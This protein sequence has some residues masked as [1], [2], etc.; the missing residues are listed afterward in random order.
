MGDNG[1]INATVVVLGDLGRS[2]RMQYHALSL[3]A[4]GA[5]VD[6]IGY[7]GSEVPKALRE[8]PRIRCHRMEPAPGRFLDRFKNSNSAMF[9]AVSLIRIAVQSLRLLGLLLFSVRKPDV[10]VLQN[11]PGIPALVILL[12]S[13]R[14]KSARLVVDW[15]NFGYTM[16]ALRLGGASR[17]VRLTRW[18]ERTLGRRADAHLCVS[19]AMQAELEKGWGFPRVAVLRDRPAEIF[20]PALAPE[21]AALRRR[22]AAMIDVDDAAYRPDAPQRPAIL[23]SPTSW[24]PDENFDLLLD[25]LARCDRA[26][27]SRATA[28]GPGFPR[29]LVLLSGEGPLRRAYEERIAR[30]G[31]EGILVRTLWLTPEDYPLLLRA[32]DLG[33]CFHRSSSGLDL[34]MKVADMLGSGLPVCALAYPCLAEQLRDGEN[35]RLFSSGAELAAEL[36]ELLEGFPDRTPGLD[37]LREN[38]LASAEPRWAD[39]WRDRAF[40]AIVE[41]RVRH[42]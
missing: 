10:L 19:R 16:L 25:A 24:T 3:A 31:L 30:L 6:L 34:P 20:T 18:Y 40:P 36:V 1:I 14:L 41:G 29:L 32:A 15:H 37:R 26:A 21:R 13:A 22:L 12:V 27:R 5:R 9:A 28:S 2:P 23:V 17:I 38:I 8:H 35:G 11:P 7:A 42:A 33:L 39:E 4:S